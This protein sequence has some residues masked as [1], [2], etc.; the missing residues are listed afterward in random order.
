MF[1]F[2]VRMS[3]TALYIGLGYNFTAAFGTSVGLFSTNG[4]VSAYEGE[5]FG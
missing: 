3:Y 1:G 5:L 4:R 2:I